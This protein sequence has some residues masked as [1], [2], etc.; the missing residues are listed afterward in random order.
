MITCRFCN[1]R[2]KLPT[3]DLFETVSQGIVALTEFNKNDEEK[4]RSEGRILEEPLKDRI[5]SS[6]QPTPKLKDDPSIQ[7]LVSIINHGDV[8]D[9]IIAEKTIDV[10][11]YRSWHFSEK[12]Q[13]LSNTLLTTWWPPLDKQVIME[14]FGIPDDSVID[15]VCFSYKV[16]GES[17]DFGFTSDLDCFT[18]N[19]KLSFSANRLVYPKDA[20]KLDCATG[21]TYVDDS[22]VVTQNCFT[23]LSGYSSMWNISQT[24]CTGSQPLFVLWGNPAIKS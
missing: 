24:I 7:T 19:G 21:L 1:G 22:L 13:P 12:K 8:D 23:D 15:H 20:F 3:E 9:P 5:L 10:L 6:F 2:V 4:K 18:I 14:R 16:S 17:A 11:C